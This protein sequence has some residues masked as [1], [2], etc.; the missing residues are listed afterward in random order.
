MR[1]VFARDLGSGETGLDRVN[2]FVRVSVKGVEDLV[3]RLLR[4]KDAAAPAELR[5]ATRKAAAPIAKAYRNLAKSHT[6]TG[7]LAQSVTTKSRLYK[8][9]AITVAGPRQTGNAS[10]DEREFASGNH[11]WLVEFGSGRRQPG[12]TARRSYVNTHKMINGRMRQAGTLNDSEFR[13]RSRG[14]TYFLMSSARE[15]TRQRKKGVGY[16]HDFLPDTRANT[17][18]NVRPMTLHPG[19]TY[20]SMPALKLMETAIMQS[21]AE[22]RS[23]MEKMIGD[24]ITRFGL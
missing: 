11:A 5:K 9:A 2:A 23:I 16:P 20:G 22:S 10:M 7:N 13:S 24:A 14:T 12:S 6:A 17:S 4:A 1:D 18:S 15:P 3:E 8:Y 21:R 19:E